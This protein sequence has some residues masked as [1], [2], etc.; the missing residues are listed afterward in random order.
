MAVHRKAA[1]ARRHSQDFPAFRCDPSVLLTLLELGSRF[2]SDRGRLTRL[3]VGLR[4]KLWSPSVPTTRI[5][6]QLSDSRTS[7][8]PT[9]PIHRR[10]TRCPPLAEPRSASTLPRPAN[11]PRASQ[12][13]RTDRRATARRSW[14]QHMLYQPRGSI[15]TTTMALTAPAPTRTRTHIHTPTHTPTLSPIPT[16]PPP[17][18]PH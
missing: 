1:F 9:T 7:T 4:Q 15:N 5:D 12:S 14:H 10:R 17:R 3:G 8:P 2:D 6:G 16:H 18:Y 13:H 11:T